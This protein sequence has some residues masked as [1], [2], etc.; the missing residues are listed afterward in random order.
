MA[1]DA[2]KKAEDFV[3]ATGKQYSV[4]QFID[5]AAKELNMKIYWKT[6]KNKYFYACND[7]NKKIIETDPRYFRPTEVHNLLGDATKARKLLKWK[8][9]IDIKKLI[10][11]M[12][13]EELK[14]IKC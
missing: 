3:I 6:D 8:P 4:R 5:L 11:E 10:K 12:I 13:E 14:E 1:Y 7:K 9:K 2:E